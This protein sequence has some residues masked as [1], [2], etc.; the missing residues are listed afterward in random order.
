LISSIVLSYNINKLT[1][2]LCDPDPVWHL[3]SCSGEVSSMNCHIRFTLLYYYNKE[4]K[5]KLSS[6]YANVNLL[7]TVCAHMRVSFGSHV[8]DDD[9]VD[10][11]A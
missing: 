10:M 4:R 7:A 2:L 5:A 6:F 8:T 3:I 1:Y 9:T 11:A